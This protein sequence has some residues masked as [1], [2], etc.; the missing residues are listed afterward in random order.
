MLL[1]VFNCAYSQMNVIRGKVTSFHKYPVKNIMV[2]AKK[3][4]SKVQTNDSGI[5]EIVCIPNDIL[6]FESQSFVPLRYKIKNI[7]DSVIVNLVFKDTEKSKEYAIAYGYMS[8]KNLT[9]AVS[10]LTNENNNF[11]VYSNVYDLIKGRFPGVNVNGSNITVRG[12]GTINGNSSALL[13]VDGVVVN[14]L[15]FINPRDIK[16]I[17]VLK[18][19]SASIYGSRGANG[20]VLIETKKP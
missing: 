1:F 13:V 15:D 18:D 6:I 4:K 3:S 5:F 2:K 14:N 19:S 8:E 11:E 7:D 12:I 16:S 20:V 17:N 9:Y 10:N